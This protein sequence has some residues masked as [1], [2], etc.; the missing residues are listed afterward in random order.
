LIAIMAGLIFCVQ[1]V[2]TGRD[3]AHRM[4]FTHSV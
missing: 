4:A 1:T 3:R 2:Q